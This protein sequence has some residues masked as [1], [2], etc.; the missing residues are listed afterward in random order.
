MKSYS[1]FREML[2]KKFWKLLLNK[3]WTFHKCKYSYTNPYVYINKWNSCI[4]Q[5]DKSKSVVLIFTCLRSH[6]PN[7]MERGV[8][9]E[10]DIFG[11]EC[12]HNINKGE[13]TKDGLQYIDRTIKHFFSLILGWLR[14][15]LGPYYKYSC[16]D[17]CV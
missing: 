3:A 1:K 10:T 6:N 7:I 5:Y 12:T 16:S 13:G 11:K 8:L 9:L 4:F 17:V 2:Y 14:S 15:M